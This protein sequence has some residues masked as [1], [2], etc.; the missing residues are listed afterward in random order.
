MATEWRGVI[1]R[2]QPQTA[3]GVHRVWKIP[4]SGGV[5][6]IHTEIGEIPQNDHAFV[7]YLIIV[8]VEGDHAQQDCSHIVHIVKQ[9]PVAPPK[10][11]TGRGIRFSNAFIWQM[12]Y[13]ATTAVKVAGHPNDKRTDEGQPRV[14]VIVA[15]P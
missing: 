1:E 9:V 6:E 12:H 8:E 2:A 11:L 15:L 14:F 13:D 10:R 5:N 7:Q 3:N 4:P